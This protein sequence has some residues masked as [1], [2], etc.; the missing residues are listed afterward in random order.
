MQVLRLGAGR[1]VVAAAVQ[2]QVVAVA[3]DAGQGAGH[4]RVAEHLSQLGHLRQEVVVGV[5]CLLQ[6]RGDAL[7]HAAVEPLGQVRAQDQ[8][9]VD[10]EPLQL[11]VGQ[12]IAG[13]IHG[14]LHRSTTWIETACIYCER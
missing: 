5:A 3:E 7:V 11:G 13:I 14:D 8:V 4:F 10:E 12:T 1:A 6:H 9:A 2:I